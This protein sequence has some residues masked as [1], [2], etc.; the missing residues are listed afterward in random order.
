MQQPAKRSDEEIVQFYVEI[1]NVRN[2]EK[3]FRHFDGR[4]QCNS[5]NK[6]RWGIWCRKM[7]NGEA[8]L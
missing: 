3:T 4:L 2:G 8:E 7:E 1:S 5:R 6:E